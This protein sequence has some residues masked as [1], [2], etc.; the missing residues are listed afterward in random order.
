M[1]G[2]LH[3]KQ[4]QLTLHHDAKNLTT[5]KE[6]SSVLIWVWKSDNDVTVRTFDG[7]EWRR[8]FPRLF[9]FAGVLVLLTEKSFITKSSPVEVVVFLF[10]FS[11]F[12]FIFFFCKAFVKLA[13]N[14]VGNSDTTS[15]CGGGGPRLV[16]EYA[17][18]GLFITFNNT[19]FDRVNV[20][21]SGTA[22]FWKQFE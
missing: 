19:F 6:S 18:D 8:T 2:G 16:E 3:W 20:E 7:R 15:L 4:Q 5:T 14:E 22:E 10:K 11:I 21:E 12:F 1:K 17:S 13:C 9:L